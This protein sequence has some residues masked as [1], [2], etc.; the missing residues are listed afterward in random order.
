M[1]EF[2]LTCMFFSILRSIKVE[3]LSKNIHF[4]EQFE[5]EVITILHICKHRFFNTV[6]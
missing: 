4:L 1:G 2:A 6:A 5:A 3:A